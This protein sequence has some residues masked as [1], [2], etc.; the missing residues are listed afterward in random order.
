MLILSLDL[1]NVKSFDG[2]HI[3]FTRGT[4][5]IVGENGA[6]KSTILEA[7]GFVLFDSIR[8]RQSDFVREGATVATITVTI[9]SSFDERRYQ[10]VR[11]CGSSGQYYVYDPDLETRIC[12]GKTDVQTFLKE[13]M[14]VEPTAAL[15]TL[16]RDAVGVP[17]GTFT[18]AFLHT[19][20]MRKGIF[21]VLLQVE[22]Y[23]RA[24]EK[25][26]EA[27]RALTDDIQN[28]NVQIAELSTRL[29]RLPALEQAIVE[30]TNVMNG[31]QKELSRTK[32]ELQALQ[33]EIEQ[34]ESK[35]HDGAA[36]T[37]QEAQLSERL[38]GIQQQITTGQ[39]AVREAKKAEELVEANQIG[40]TRY[41]EMDVKLTELRNRQQQRQELEGKRGNC[42]I[43]LAKASTEQNAA[44]KRL[45]QAEE[46]KMLVDKL[47]DSVAKQ[48]ELEKKLTKLQQQALLAANTKQSIKEQKSRLQTQHARYTKLTGQLTQADELDA[49][50][51]QQ[52]QR[53]AEHRA[54]LTEDQQWLAQ[55]EAE[56]NAIKEQ[57]RLL[58]ESE[59]VLCPVCEQPLNDTHRVDL[60]NQNESKLA[61]RR[62]QYVERRKQSKQ[63][64]T[65]IEKIEHSISKLA[66]EIQRL[67][68]IDEV[69]S[70]SADIEQITQTLNEAHEQL[71]KF[72]QIPVHIEQVETELT[73]LN[74]PRQ[75]QAVAKEV[76][77]QGVT[78][79]KRYR[80]ISATLEAAQKELETVT[81]Q[82]EEFRQIDHD[83][84]ETTK[85]M[86]EFEPAYQLV[87]ANQQ[88]ARMVQER[89][90]TLDKMNEEYE[91]TEQKHQQAIKELEQVAASFD[92]EQYQQVLANDR[93]L[94]AE[95]GRIEIQLTLYQ[96]EQSRDQASVEDL[97]QYQAHLEQV[98]RQKA[99]NE[100]EA[101]A[102]DHIRTV[103]R[104]SGP[105]IT[106]ALI[107]QISYGASQI[108]SDLMQDYSCRLSWTE[109]YAICVETDGRERQFPQLSGGEQMSAALAVRVALLRE[110][111][112]IDIAFF[113]E[114]TM[115][116]D[117]KRREQLAKQIS[118]VKGFQQ[119]LVISHDDTFE[120]TTDHIIRIE[121]KNGVSIIQEPELK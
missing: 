106:K 4:N 18:A 39:Q 52:Q 19:P 97:K 102:L 40:F 105:F 70:I 54:E 42:E 75:R 93:N 27:G 60:L 26:L 2:A 59:T 79:K 103:L 14:K 84:A 34:Y 63:K 117:T 67:P 10:V 29:E 41:Q 50:R 21:D 96:E 76:A 22:E 111:S 95:L 109:D 71:H 118:Q 61:Q 30:R 6:G 98:N 80:N 77:S 108:F 110:M 49:K 115:N 62:L 9:I 43:R 45:I 24:A 89:Q 7:I 112:D 73:R 116:L 25:L 114:P 38:A 85:F 28:A 11:R 13:H 46:A 31:L 16:F 94:R 88:M 66:H 37:Q 104:Q 12:M 72:E 8:Y 15:D 65:V 57:S 74:N 44:Q 92:P 32:S 1:D 82:L 36:L 55:C 86:R 90:A 120:Q 119:V 23:K 91:D 47:T 20:T 3:D 100:R 121:K 83:I 68:R 58:Q 78:L 99:K 69:E 87:L 101:N 33:Q 35:Q 107:Q 48:S 64:S 56:A 81:I 51:Q 17:Q 113:D 53:L 5:A